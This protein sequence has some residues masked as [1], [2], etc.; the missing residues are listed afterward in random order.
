MLT[1]GEIEREW[2]VWKVYTRLGIDINPR[3]QQIGFKQEYFQL[4]LF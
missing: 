2:Y 1:I 3:W 4:K